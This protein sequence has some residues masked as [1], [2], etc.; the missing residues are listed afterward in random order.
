MAD[1][2]FANDKLNSGNTQ[3]SINPKKRMVVK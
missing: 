3:K 2:Y 1:L